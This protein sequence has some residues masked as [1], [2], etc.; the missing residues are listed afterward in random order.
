MKLAAAALVIFACPIG[1]IALAEEPTNE[2]V[3]A[4][5]G[6]ST[7][8]PIESHKNYF[9]VRITSNPGGGLF[10]NRRLSD[11]W[12]LGI[13]GSLGQ[14]LDNSSEGGNLDA[15]RYYKDEFTVKTKF[16][17]LDTTYFFRNQG[18]KRW[19]FLVRGGVGYEDRQAYGKW[20][21]YDRSPAWLIFGDGKREQE[22]NETRADWSSA[23]AR[24]GGYYQFMWTRSTEALI[25]GHV[26][27]IGLSGLVEAR[28]GELSYKKSDGSIVSKS[29]Q[30]VEPVAEISYS[31]VF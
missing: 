17:E 21:R 1:S 7:E 16:I 22:S 25:V 26:L 27:E 29:S 24:A 12:L 6:P 5:P 3:I 2:S 9:G 20:T 4:L 19:G 30:A 14:T 11:K 10:Y 28:R 13:A 18:Y 8:A 15:G 23:Y 31:F